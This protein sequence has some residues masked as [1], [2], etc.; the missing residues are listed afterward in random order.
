LAPDDPYWGRTAPLTSKLC[1]LYIHST[2]ICIEYFK[3]GIFS[4]FFSLQNA[5]CFIILTYLLPV[6][7][8]FYIQNVLKLKKKISGATRLN[9]N[10][11]KEQCMLPEDD[12]MIETCRSVLSVLMWISDHQTNICAFV[13]VLIK[14]NYRM[15][16]ATIKIHGFSSFL[17]LNFLHVPSPRKALKE[18]RFESRRRDKICL[19]P[20]AGPNHL[21][22]Q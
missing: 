3:R 13:G 7:F 4:P 22:V 12:R 14:I 18:C 17:Y 21:P 6:L 9:Y 11:S 20:I 10:F 15:N 2:N 19:Y 16:G 5:I 8:T 1:I